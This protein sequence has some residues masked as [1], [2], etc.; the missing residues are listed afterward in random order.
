MFCWEEWKW[1]SDGTCIWKDNFDLSLENELEGGPLSRSGALAVKGLL[2]VEGDSSLDRVMVA[3]VEEGRKLRDLGGKQVD[4]IRGWL[5]EVEGRD[6]D[7]S[8]VSGLAG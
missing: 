7:D 3:D 5:Q 6:I 4:F 8:Q 2:L 1:G